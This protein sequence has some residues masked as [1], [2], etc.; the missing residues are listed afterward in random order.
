[1]NIAFVSHI[2]FLGNS[3]MHVFNIAEELIKLGHDCVVIVPSKPETAR[4]HGIS[5]FVS[6]NFDQA[7]KGELPFRNG[8][9]PDLV[10]AWTPRENVRLIVEGLVDRYRCPYLVHMEDNEEQIISSESQTFSY[11]EISRLPTQLAE[12]CI[13]DGFRRSIPHRYELFIERSSGYT[14]LIDRLLEFK[15][16]RTPGLVFWPGFEPEFADADRLRA[17]AR[18]R[19]NVDDDTTVLVY[20]GGSPVAMA[21]DLRRLYL[22]V[23]ALWRRG[24][25]IKLFKTGRGHPG[26]GLDERHHVDEFIVNLGFL[27]RA[28]LPALIGMADIL[29]QPGRSD[30]FND[31]RFPSKLPEFLVSGRPVI[32]PDSNIGKVLRDREQALLLREGSIAEISSAIRELIADHALRARIGANGRQ[33]A[34]EQLSWQKAGRL[35]DGLYQSIRES[36]VASPSAPG[37]QA[38]STL[39]AAPRESP[40]QGGDVE[41]SIPAKLVAFYL[42]QFHPIPE[43][44]S[45]WGEGFTEWTNVTRA[46]PLFAG[47]RQPR[48]PA[49]LG[50]YDLRVGEVMHQQAA[51]ARQYGIFGFCFYYYWFSGRRLLE[52]PLDY[53]VS[54]A[55]PDFP[56]C[57]C[58]ANEN[59][60]RRWDGSAHEILMSQT[61]SVDNDKRFFEDVLPLLRHRSYIRVRGA[62]MLLVYRVTE[63]PDPAGTAATWRRLAAAAGLPGIFLVAVQFSKARD[64]RPFGFDAAVQFAPWAVGGRGR[65]D[66]SKIKDI[67]EGFRGSIEDYIALVMQ[68]VNDPPT[69]YVRYRCAF[70]N[71]DNTPRRREKGYM[72]LNA[73][74]KA[75]GQWLRYLVA[76]AV[77]M[78]HRQEPFVFINAW[79]EWAEGAFLEPDRDFGRALLEVTYAALYEGIVDCARG[80]TAERERVFTNSVSRLPVTP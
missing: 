7:R 21:P 28:E 70:P 63:L 6:I 80:R 10:H 78:R 59:W 62:P 76:E 47:H 71:W 46:K 15:P 60:S 43:N 66:P 44:N 8:L 38:G 30:A 19:F 2:D 4:Q 55:G 1:M 39:S 41:P 26:L 49:D 53:W 18:A 65:L 52:R 54:D 29:V 37:A 33:F 25:R 68:S 22:A 74:P 14:C 77:Q 32:L 69:E 61:Y 5:H 67:G 64:P 56:F 75:Y 3:G 9:D 12:D 24:F 17:R 42:P 48:L 27:P 45:W 72:F 79:N 51:L 36:A 57:L 16:D 23:G 35:I 73:S 31:Y 11:D 58:W 34:L 20:S 13:A 50:F 40:S